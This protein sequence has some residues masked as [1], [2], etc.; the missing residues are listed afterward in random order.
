MDT[1]FH[2][3]T[4]IVA[5]RNWFTFSLLHMVMIDDHVAFAKAHAPLGIFCGYSPHLLQLLHGAEAV[6]S[7]RTAAVFTRSSWSL[8]NRMHKLL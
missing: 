4:H 6:S 3:P 5:D 2:T 1:V 7:W 8:I